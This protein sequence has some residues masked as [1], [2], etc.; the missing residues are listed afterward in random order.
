M[1]SNPGIFYSQYKDFTRFSS[2]SV[3][4][5]YKGFNNFSESLSSAQKHDEEL[6]LSLLLVNLSTV[7]KSDKRTAY[8]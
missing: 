3:L 4:M 6:L 5:Y 7:T 2:E 1:L 8:K